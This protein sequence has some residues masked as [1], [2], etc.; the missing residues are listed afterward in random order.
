[1]LAQAAPTAACE[2]AA[3]LKLNPM[4]LCEDPGN[5]T[6]RNLP[7]G[8]V[9]YAEALQ[10]FSGKDYGEQCLSFGSKERLV[11]LEHAK[12]NSSWI[13]GILVSAGGWLPTQCWVPLMEAPAPPSPPPGPPVGRSGAGRSS[14]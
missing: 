7:G 9:V 14:A 2:R 1:M 5:V 4:E 3:L 11:L 8:A 13:Y 6:Q 10:D 12:A